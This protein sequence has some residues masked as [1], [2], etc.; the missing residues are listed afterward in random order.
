MKYLQ[1]RQPPQRRPKSLLKSEKGMATLETIPL[2]FI[3]IYLLC[4]TL[5]G[6][7]I[8]HT[9]I[10]NS[11]AARAYAFE[12]FRNRSNL[13][14]FRDT[15]PAQL[16]EL[17]TVGCRVH[18]IMSEGPRA[19][20]SSFRASERPLRVGIAMEPDGSRNDPNI[21][22][23]KVFDPGS[24]ADKKRNTTVGTSPVWVMVQYG[25][26]LDVNCGG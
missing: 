24:I 19:D 18:G 21:H 8:V 23:V 2:L 5:G 11:I 14:Y 22:N 9:G 4:Y 6:F 17:R 3:F 12:T 26:C 10:K 15:P 13:V 1:V 20:D 7:G 16:L 25:I